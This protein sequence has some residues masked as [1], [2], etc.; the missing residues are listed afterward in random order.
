MNER[1]KILRKALGLTQQEFADRIGGNRNTFANYESGRIE[2]SAAA[3]SSICREFHVNES[4][5]RS[6]EGE[7]F[8]PQNRGELIRSFMEDVLSDEPDSFRLRLISALTKLDQQEWEMLAR[9]AERLAL[10]NT[11]SASP[12]GGPTVGEAEDLYKKSLP[13]AQDSGSTASSTIEDT[14]A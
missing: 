10:E 13:G 2:P 6:G 11:P 14:P 4:W 5:L 7:M 1:I 9:V 8:L 12:A 3:F